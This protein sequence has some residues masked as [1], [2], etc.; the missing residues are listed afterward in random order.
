MS[1]DR[2]STMPAMMALTKLRSQ[3][4]HELATA[5]RLSTASTASTR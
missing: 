3:K 1:S 5:A 2:S 4:F